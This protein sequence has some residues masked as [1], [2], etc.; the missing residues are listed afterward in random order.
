MLH[1]DAFGQLELEIAWLQAAL[2]QGRAHVSE[3]VRV[4]QLDGGDIDGDG[5][6]PAGVDPGPRLPARFAQNPSADLQNEARVFGDR[7]EVCGQDESSLG[8]PPPDQRL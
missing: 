5:H 2:L 6:G 3:K 7:Y 4:P 8:I 1:E